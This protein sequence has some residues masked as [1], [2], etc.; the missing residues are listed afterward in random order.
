M[1]ID[2]KPSIVADGPQRPVKGTSDRLET[3]AARRRDTDD[4]AE[5]RR[6]A[7]E[8][9][10]FREGLSVARVDAEKTAGHGLF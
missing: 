1:R 9:E 4:P 8:I 3:L 6:L 10:V 2:E 5:A 7:A